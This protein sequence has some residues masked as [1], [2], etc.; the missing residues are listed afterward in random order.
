MR[1]HLVE[2]FNNTAHGNGVHGLRI[3]PTYL[4]LN[5]PCDGSSGSAPQYF[6]NFTSYRN[7]AHGIFG[8]NNG[9]LHHV[10]ANLVENGGADQLW[11]KLKS[12]AFA[13]DKPHIVDG[14]FVAHTDP[15]V[16]VNK[17][18]LF[19]PQDEYWHVEGATFVNYKDSGAIAACAGCDSDQFMKQGGYTYRFA[20]L[21]F[22]NTAK[23][24]E[25]K[26]PFKQIFF[27]LDGSLTGHTGGTACPMYDYNRCPE[28]SEGGSVYDDGLVCDN[29]VRV[30]RLQVCQA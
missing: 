3:Y 13:E 11:F 5:D 15:N 20:G 7:G 19:G 21:Q 23:R 22:D 9:D 28:C 27:D 14:L 6:Y 1:D 4:P 29:R 24:V 25:W 12:I 16:V 10:G 30:R 18:G 26:P 2:F 8:K 17:V